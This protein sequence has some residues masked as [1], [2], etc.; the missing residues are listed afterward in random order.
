MM[1]IFDEASFL[2]VVI[3]QRVAKLAPKLDASGR[4]DFRVGL[5]GVR[6]WLIDGQRRLT[7]KIILNNS[8][9]LKCQDMA[10]HLSRIPATQN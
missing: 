9:N 8:I 2:A 4:D 3:D 6:A 5:P 10:V 7:G 1:T